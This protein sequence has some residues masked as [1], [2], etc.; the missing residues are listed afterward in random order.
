VSF[1]ARPSPSVKPT[2][3]IEL[4]QKDKALLENI[5][6]YLGVGNIYINQGHRSLQFKVQS[7]KD[8]VLL[9]KH[10][11]KYPL[12]TQKRSDYELFKQAVEL[13]EQKEHLTSEG[14][15]KIVALKA[16]MNMGLSPVLK[17]AFPHV[18]PVTRPSGLEQKIPN[19]DWLAGFTS[20]EG[21]FMIKTNN[22]S[23]PRLGLQVQ[24][25]FNLAQH[26]RDEWLMRSLIDYFDCGNVYFH[27]EGIEYRIRKFSDQTD[28]VIPLF[29]KYPIIGVKSKDFADFCKAAEL[30]KNKAHLSQDGLDQ[31]RK[32][33]AGM[34]TVRK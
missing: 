22:S 6:S 20:G 27:R 18:I 26:S 14:L 5:Q 15:A 31:I 16:S 33:K 30:I 23:S 13:M 7:V 2:F 17:A 21:C 9:L 1:I 11:E 28:K 32:I 8:L 29:N 4:H 24:L 34:N 3:Q 10:F 19:P 12:L 25:E